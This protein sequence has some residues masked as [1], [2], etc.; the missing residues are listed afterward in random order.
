VAGTQSGTLTL[1]SAQFS[2]RFMNYTGDI[3][4]DYHLQ[5]GAVAIDRGTTLCA[6]GRERLRAAAR[7]PPASARPQGAAYDIG[8]YEWR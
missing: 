2:A 6:A 5:S 7:L 8:P 1:T 4:G 3:T